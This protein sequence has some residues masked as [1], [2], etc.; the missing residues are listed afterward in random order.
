LSIHY[1]PLGDLESQLM[2]VQ[3]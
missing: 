3:R 1:N 2:L